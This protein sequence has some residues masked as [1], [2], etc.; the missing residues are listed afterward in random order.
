MAHI[1]IYWTLLISVC[2]YAMLRGGAPE[3]WVA[4]ILILGTILTN[5]AGRWTGDPFLRFHPAAF[6]VDLA[7]LIAF[8]VIAE[9]STRYW[10]L[11]VAALQIWQVASHF[12]TWLPGI[13]GLVYSLALTFWAYPMLLILA[14]GTWRHDMRVRRLGSD[15]SWSTRPMA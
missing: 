10:P 15:H 9:R 8:M 6:A 14:A 11:W 7:A 4:A 1:L 5:L 13:F 12:V 3:R 2:G